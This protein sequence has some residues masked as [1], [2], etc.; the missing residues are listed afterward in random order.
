MKTGKNI[1]KWK[2]EGVREFLMMSLCNQLARHTVNKNV[3]F[4]LKLP[5][6]ALPII[7]RLKTTETPSVADTT[8]MG[9]KIEVY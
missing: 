2:N 9:R 6:E 8:I 4:K 3:D 7:L 5:I 1:E